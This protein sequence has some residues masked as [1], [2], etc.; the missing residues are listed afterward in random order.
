MSA[1][2]RDR[3]LSLAIGLALIVPVAWGQSTRPINSFVQQAI[4][5]AAWCAVLMLLPR[6]AHGPGQAA[7]RNPALWAAAAGLGLCL[8][9]ALPAAPHGFLPEILV[10]LLGLLLMLSAARQGRPEALFAPLAWGLWA[11][12]LLSVLIV[13]HQHLWPCQG[14]GHWIALNRAGR[15]FGNLRQPN[16]MG[17]YLVMALSAGAWLAQDGRIGSGRAGRALALLGAGALMLALAMTASRTA[18]LALL[19]L[20]AW[21][22]LDRRLGRGLRG[23]LIAAPL[24]YEIGRAHV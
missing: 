7:Q 5:V 16:L 20:S 3:L 23:L 17:T 2:G 11:G 14:D 18:A 22:V 19:L 10:M 24:A 4:A 13:G 15:A 6:A 1:T 8:L 21:G 9:A 12:G